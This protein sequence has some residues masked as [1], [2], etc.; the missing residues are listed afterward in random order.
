MFNG[1]P[2]GSSGRIVAN[3]D[4]QTKGMGH[5]DLKLQLLATRPIAVATTAIS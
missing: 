4:S 1:I 3:G 5:F 2:I